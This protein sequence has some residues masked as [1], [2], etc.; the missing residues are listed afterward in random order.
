MKE[1]EDKG[2]TKAQGNIAIATRMLSNQIKDASFPYFTVPSYESYKLY[3]IPPYAVPL[4]TSHEHALHIANKTH[5]YLDS[6]AMR[7]FSGLK[8]DFTQLKH[9]AIPEIVHVANGQTTEAIGYGTIQL[10]TSHG[11]RQFKNA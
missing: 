7:H 8:S 11:K 10:Q 1:Q 6:G 9:W 5:S 2:N 4:V 3:A